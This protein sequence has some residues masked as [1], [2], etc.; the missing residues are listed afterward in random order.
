MVSEDREQQILELL[1][2]ILRW[3]KIG[4]LNLRE[5]LVQ[6]LD[7]DQKRLVY[8]LTD[9]SRSGREIEGISGVP[10]RTVNNWWS[11]WKELGFVDPSPKYERR[12]QWLCSLRMLGIAIPEVVGRTTNDGCKPRK[13]R[14]K[15]EVEEYDEGKQSKMGSG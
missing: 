3:T 6:V 11:R 7:G 4:A 12:V 2:E 8:E 10:T 14:T 15:R 1:S 13:R 5:S 9:G